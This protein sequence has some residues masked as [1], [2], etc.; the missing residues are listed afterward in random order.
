MQSLIIT[1]YFMC[2]PTQGRA[3]AG[4]SYRRGGGGRPAGPYR[5]SASPLFLGGTTRL[6]GLR[7]SLAKTYSASPGFEC[8][9]FVG[10]QPAASFCT[11]FSARRPA[12]NRAQYWWFRVLGFRTLGCPPAVRASFCTRIS[13]GRILDLARTPVTTLIIKLRAE[14]CPFL[15]QMPKSW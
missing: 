2:K 9:E 4:E 10:F 15:R 3:G 8:F 1:N 5:R 11:R 14:S 13:A 7:V 12:E 6:H